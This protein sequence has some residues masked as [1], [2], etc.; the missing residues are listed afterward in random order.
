MIAVVKEGLTERWRREGVGRRTRYKR[1]GVRSEGVLGERKRGTSIRWRTRETE[2]EK[3]QNWLGLTQ[4][5]GVEIS[6]PVGVWRGHSS[7]WGGGDK[8][9]CNSAMIKYS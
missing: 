8:C 1:D 3:E 7:R 2:S 9:C 5:W 6:K 4:R